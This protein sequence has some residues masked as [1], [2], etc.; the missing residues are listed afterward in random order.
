[1][2][3]LVRGNLDEYVASAIELGAGRERLRELRRRLQESRDRC[4][5]FDTPGLVRDLERLHLQMW[6][7]YA[8]GLLP[9][10]DL[11]NLDIYHDI[12]CRIHGGRGEAGEAGDAHYRD[13]LCYRSGVSRLPADGRLWPRESPGPDTLPFALAAE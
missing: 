8:R 1:L 2:P 5:L 11:A 6:D 3:E 13:A 10:P 9:E 12:A 4:V 7:A